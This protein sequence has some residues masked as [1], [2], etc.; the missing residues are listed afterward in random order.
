MQKDTNLNTTGSLK[1]LLSITI[2]N[3]NLKTLFFNCDWFDH[4]HG[5]RENEFIM[6]AVKLDC[7]V[8]THLSLLTRSSKSIIC[9][10]HA[11]S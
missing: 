2:R 7:V 4:N 1:T 6:V 8:A 5:T 11:K 3:K 9:C 10:T